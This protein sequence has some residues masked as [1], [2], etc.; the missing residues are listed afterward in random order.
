MKVSKRKIEFV[1]AGLLAMGLAGAAIA[2][3]AASN[4]AARQK[5]M[6]DVQANMQAV[7]SAAGKGDMA[8][9]KEAALKINAAFK[10]ASTRFTAGSDAAAGKTRAKAEVWSD[11]TGFKAKIDGAIATS[12]KLVAATG[13]T[14]MAAVQTAAGDV[15]ALCY[16]CHT[17]Y[18]GS[19]R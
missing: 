9:A 13:G 16:G 11:A 12:D 1:V 10:D 4:I 5:D 7:N 17:P 6:Q 2:Q 19:G 14:D 3:D 8:A 15:N 18:R